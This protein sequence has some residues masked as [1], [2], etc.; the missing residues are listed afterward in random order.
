MIEIYIHSYPAPPKIPELATISSDD[1][2]ELETK[3]R[4]WPVEICIDGFSP[5]TALIKD[6]FVEADYSTVFEEYLRSS[7]QPRWS[8]QSLVPDE[9]GP[10][11]S[12]DEISLAE[13]R[14]GQYGIS[15]FNQL[16]EQAS[17]FRNGIYNAQIYVV[18]HHDSDLTNRNVGGV[19]C[20]AWELLE[21]VQIQDKPK[22]HLRVTRLS[23]FPARRHLC[24]PPT[25]QRLTD[26]QAD[27][28][29]T[30]KILLVIA[31][32]FSHKGA[33]RDPEPD[34]AQWPLM[35]LQRRLRS[36][37]TLEIVRPGSLEELE[38]HLQ[39][40]AEQNIIFNLVHFDLHGRIIR[41]GAGGAVPWLLF[42]KKHAATDSGVS[43][44]RTQLVDAEYVAEV[45]ARFQV[46]NVVLNAC[47]SAY[48]RSGPAT[49]LAHIFLRYG[50]A[51]V[52]AMWFY[53]HWKTV[54]TYVQAFYDRLLIKG[55][56]FH[57]AA[58]RAREALRE[59]PT[60]LTGRTYQD[61][62]LCVNYARN[63]HTADSVVREVSPSPS[64]R[65][66][67]SATSTS[68]NSVKSIRSGLL[69]KTSPRIAESL[70]LGDEPIMRLQL[71]LLEL[72]FKLMTC[73]IVYA[74]AM[75]QNDSNL[76]AT[77][78][79]MINM[80]L[81]TNLID[82]VHF[83]KAKDFGRRKM[84]SAN[85]AVSP[86]EK[87]TRASTSG[88]LQRWFPRSIGSLRQTLHI[89]RE[90]DSVVDPGYHFDEQENQRYGERQFLAQEGLQK[91]ATKLHEDGHS[92]LIFLGSQ[93]E[94]WWGTN[95]KYLQGAW[96][97]NGPW[98]FTV[99]TRYVPDAKRSVGLGKRQPIGLEVG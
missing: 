71:H 85:V 98:G 97:L 94:Q 61:F 99:H 45:L 34:L 1:G 43:I 51:N 86:R 78:D 53:V 67:D 77:M 83:Y 4:D 96:W 55:L 32:D 17:L 81:S 48:N 93:N 39:V 27:P 76:E 16:N 79:K 13:E 91:F 50:I 37:L 58:Q 21:S 23:D 30:F 5:I 90:V 66:H 64:A 63:E 15:L 11:L 84:L 10:G 87:R 60:V 31:R 20:L 47:L 24:L 44:P 19:H 36:R 82:E 59:Q 8:S 72:E 57:T 92:Y 75:D 52:S 54:A 29:A 62:F 49:N 3:R 26:V 68:V 22:L 73:K 35:N 46:E 12:V 69:A 25:A 2:E 38:W 18:E 65:S 70:I 56:P 42:A 9:T 28:N 14:I 33:E 74:S 40:R 88:P 95:L 41:D 89:V 6:P 80:W 7:D